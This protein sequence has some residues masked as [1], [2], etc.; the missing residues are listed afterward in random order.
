MLAGI[1]EEMLELGA[2]EDRVVE[3]LGGA[4][5]GV[6]GGVTRLLEMVRM[7]TREHSEGWGTEEDR[8]S[9]IGNPLALS[10]SDACKLQRQ[11]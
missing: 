9:H 10:P 2:E 3:L 5:G 7:R 6:W 11:R 1:T 4:G 8:R